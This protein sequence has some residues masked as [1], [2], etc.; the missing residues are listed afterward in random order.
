MNDPRRLIEEGAT[1]FESKLL[2]AGRRDAPSRRGRRRILA[3]LGLGGIFSTIAI[4]TGA[5]ASARGWL[6]AAGGSA[7]G[8]LAVF[9]GVQAWSAQPPSEAHEQKPVVTKPAPL[10]AKAPA[11]VAAPPV[12]ASEPDPAPTAV[13]RALRS[14]AVERRGD[15][16]TGELAALDEARRALGRN[17]PSVALRALDDYSRSFPERRLGSEAT[18]LRVE[19]LSAA[20]DRA[21]ARRVGEDFLRAHP[22]SPYEKR[23]RSLIESA[24]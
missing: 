8:A 5:E 20:G 18:V 17:E 13:L 4:S 16:L 12:E 19:A 24:P 9:A 1:D 21:H 23:I 15:G 2:R 22:K 14:S 10:P 11:P 6:L 3:G 7:A